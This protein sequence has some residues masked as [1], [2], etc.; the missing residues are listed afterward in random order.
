[1]LLADQDRDR[2]DH[3][4]IAEA[5]A[6]LRTALARRQ[7]GAY[8]LQA[9]IACLHGLSPSA[10]AT[11]WGQIAE[12][13]GVLAELRPTP[14]VALNRAVAVAEAVDPARG[15]ALLDEIEGLD[16][17]FR[18]HGVR[19]ELLWRAGRRREAV[20]AGRVAVDLAPEGVDRRQLRRR[21]ADYEAG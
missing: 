21:L 13:Y 17:W 4:A 8:Q 12:L 18:F 5:D 9:A 16:R 1:M 19:A 15:L 14:V 11:D 20:E 7:L 2:W 6:L 10:A 3:A